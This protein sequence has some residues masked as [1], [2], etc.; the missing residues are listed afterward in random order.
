MIDINKLFTEEK[1]EL[2]QTSK[3]INVLTILA[4]EVN[5]RIRANV[6]RNPNT[7]VE[8]LDIL[9]KDTDWQVRVGIS[10]HPNIST[11]ALSILAKDKNLSVRYHVAYNKNTSIKVLKKLINDEVEIVRETAIKRLAEL[12]GLN[13]F[14]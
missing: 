6:A 10:Y 8:I 14:I 1:I 5:W 11:E 4:K 9:A 3:D 2:A 13:S 12:K 7:P